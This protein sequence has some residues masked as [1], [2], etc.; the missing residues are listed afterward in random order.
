M[1]LGHDGVLL[2]LTR[3]AA[4]AQRRRSTAGRT[5]THEIGR[6]RL[7]RMLLSFQRPSRHPSPGDSRRG[8]DAGAIG[9]YRAGKQL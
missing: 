7:E 4:V 1:G 3:T 5:W 8:H 6:S 2:F 9:A